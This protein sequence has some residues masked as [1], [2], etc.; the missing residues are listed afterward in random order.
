MLDQHGVSRFHSV[1]AEQ[2]RSVVDSLNGGSSWRHQVDP[3]MPP[4]PVQRIRHSAHN[5]RK[6][7]PERKSCSTTGATLER[8]T[9]FI[10][11]LFPE[12][13]LTRSW[14]FEHLCGIQDQGVVFVGCEGPFSREEGQRSAVS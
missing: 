1:R 14:P 8:K 13:Q 11:D 6:T 4:S 3:E 5:W 12:R 9:V 2:H 7:E 10:G